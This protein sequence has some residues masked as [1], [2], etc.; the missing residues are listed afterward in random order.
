[1]FEG[2][3]CLSFQAGSERPATA[4]HSHTKSD[5]DKRARSAGRRDVSKAARI[6]KLPIAVAQEL[7][8]PFLMPV[9]V[10]ARPIKFEIQISDSYRALIFTEE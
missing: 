6:N 4:I 3:A 9:T 2:I 7:S 5:D 8:A 10:T 1:M